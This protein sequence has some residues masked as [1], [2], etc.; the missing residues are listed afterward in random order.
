MSRQQIEG[1]F[2]IEKYGDWATTLYDP[3]GRRFAFI[4]SFSATP[5]KAIPPKR[6]TETPFYEVRSNGSGGQEILSVDGTVVVWTT[7]EVMA[8]LICKLLKLH[9][10]VA[11]KRASG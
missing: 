10:K 2:V 7:D 3:D 4:S 11:D 5:K 1:G 9:K 6:P 8:A